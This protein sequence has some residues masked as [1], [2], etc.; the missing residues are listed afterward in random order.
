MDAV[1][2]R[3]ALRLAPSKASSLT[4]KWIWISAAIFAHDVDIILSAQHFNPLAFWV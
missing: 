1:S 4:G 2:E 3:N